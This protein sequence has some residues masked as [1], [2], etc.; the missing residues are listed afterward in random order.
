MQAA[1]RDSLA[2]RAVREA[3]ARAEAADWR[4]RLMDKLA[5]DE[6]LEQMADA[7][8][9]ARQAEHRREAERLR[10]V[11]QAMV[12]AAAA[13]EAAAEGAEQRRRNADDGIVAAERARLLREQAVGL[14]PF[15]PKGVAASGADLELILSLEH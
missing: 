7:R 13:A 4:Q 1:Y 3:A 15:L 2:E 10:A 11:K 8:R 6:R 14:L 5:A 12:D 9:R